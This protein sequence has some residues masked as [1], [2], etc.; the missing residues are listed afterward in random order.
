MVVVMTVLVWISVV[1]SLAKND[2]LWR[3]ALVYHTNIASGV[4]GGVIVAS[5]DYGGG[6]VGSV[7]VVNAFVLVALVIVIKAS[8]KCLLSGCGGV[9]GGG[10]GGICCGVGCDVGF[11]GVGGGGSGSVGGNGCGG[12]DGDGDGG[13]GFLEVAVAIVVFWFI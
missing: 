2:S 10:C 6:W 5:G 3:V 9:C 7:V 13:G 12:G 11:D 1:L 8:P 4:G